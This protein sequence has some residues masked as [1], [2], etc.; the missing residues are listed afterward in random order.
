MTCQRIAGSESSSQSMTFTPF[1]QL[2]WGVATRA[3]A[4]FSP[5]FR[6]RPCGIVASDADTPWQ[7]SRQG[8]RQARSRSFTWRAM[9]EAALA[10]DRGGT[11][12]GLMAD[13]ERMTTIRSAYDMWPQ[14]N[15][16]VRDAIA[17]MTDVQLALRPAPKVLPMWAAMGHTAAMRVYWLC[18]V[19]G[20]DGAETTPFWRDETT[21]DW[22]DDL[23]HPRSAKELAKAFDATFAI[24]EGC[25][26]RWTVDMLADEIRRDYGD[27]VQV[28]ARSSILQRLLTHE[29]WHAA[30]LSL[31]QGMQGMPQV[32]LWR[33]D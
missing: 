4:A 32:D 7:E 6:V 12:S 9:D 31:A 26:D 24:V 14:Y 2:Q 20:E 10:R 33:S 29:A 27:T 22:A 13:H 21:V 8:T 30:E 19:M 15:R 11:T 16:R 17:T 25:L 23:D 28:H 1:L 18:E 3:A 5:A